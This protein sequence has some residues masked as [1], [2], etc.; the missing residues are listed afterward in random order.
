MR[1]EWYQKSKKT[2][3]SGVRRIQ[4]EE[5]VSNTFLKRENGRKKREFIK[6]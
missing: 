6:G 5:K 4:G 3:A 2:K 1:R